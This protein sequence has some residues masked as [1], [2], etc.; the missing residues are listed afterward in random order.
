MGTDRF[1]W[2][3]LA[4]YCQ[5]SG[6]GGTNYTQRTVAG[7]RVWVRFTWGR[8]EGESIPLIHVIV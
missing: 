1:I 5:G 8:T 6:A 7:L 4:E 2:G 3:F